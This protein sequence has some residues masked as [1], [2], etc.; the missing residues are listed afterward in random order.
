MVEVEDY[1]SGKG[2]T[3]QKDTDGYWQICIVN[4]RLEV[5]KWV[6]QDRCNKTDASFGQNGT[7]SIVGAGAPLVFTSDKNGL[8]QIYKADYN[9]ETL[10][11]FKQIS[12]SKSDNTS[13]CWAFFSKKVYFV[14]GSNGHRRIAV[15]NA[16][17]QNQRIL[18]LK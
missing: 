6:T 18:E 17:G 1:N 4:N 12:N 16:D 3:C 15:I 14:I 7:L 5:E 8:S 10:T 2:I 13:P 9:K 11:N